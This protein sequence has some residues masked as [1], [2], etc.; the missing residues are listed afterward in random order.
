MTNDFQHASGDKVQKVGGSYQATGTVVSA[1]KT[2]A[3]EVRYVFEFDLP[4]GMLHIFG[5]S[6][7]APL[8]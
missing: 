4:A 2:V 1:F 8:K 5:P 6:Q 7:I 3:G